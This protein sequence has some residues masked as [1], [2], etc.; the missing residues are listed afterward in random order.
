MN[1]INKSYP[2]HLLL[3]SVAPIF[4]LMPKSIMNFRYYLKTGKFINWHRPENVQEFVLNNIY[5]D[6][7]DKS[8]LNLYSNVTDK[9]RA[10]DFVKD[11]IGEKYLTK[12][13]GI[14]ERPEDINF[15][16]LPTPCVIKTNNGCSTN[17]I[18][19]ERKD[20]DSDK[21]VSKLKKWLKYPYGKLS[22]QP[23]YTNIKPL[24]LAEEYLEQTPGMSDLPYDYK[25]FC[26]N[27]NPHFILF[28]S[29]RKINGH[30]SKNL[31]F[32][33]QWNII[34]NVAN[35]PVLNKNVPKP[36]CLDEMLKVAKELSKGFRFVRVDLYAIGKRVVF[37]EM[38]LTPDM[39][40]NFKIDFL[41]DYLD[42]I[43]Q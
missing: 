3:K 42:K 22:G 12:L 24:I 43:K 9:V 7:K 38:T 35:F 20:L 5:R 2:I 41:S 23:H 1:L 26:F 21:I 30:D 16:S 14:W 27:G 29:D 25:F 18:I 10:R 13:Y 40:T 36:E 28:Y 11:R 6:I 37:G 15:D 32:D 17:I 8:L 39:V 31:V 19:R 4:G 33:T 34:D